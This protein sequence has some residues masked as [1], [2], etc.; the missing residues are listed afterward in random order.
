MNVEELDR[1]LDV[2]ECSY[3]VEMISNASDKSSPECL[4]YMDSDTSGSWSRISSFRYLDAE[5][6]PALHRILYLP[7]DREGKVQFK[8]YNLYSKSKLKTEI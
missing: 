7:F 3:I 4:H 2:S 1:Y 5:L 8:E 6:T